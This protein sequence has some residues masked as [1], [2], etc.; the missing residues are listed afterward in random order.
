MSG[1]INEAEGT[2]PQRDPSAFSRWCGRLVPVL[3]ALLTFLVI[4]PSLDAVGEQPDSADAPGLTLDEIFNIQT[5]VYLWRS[6]VLE[7]PGYFTP[8][9]AER[10]Y[11]QPQ[12]NPDHPPLGRLAI[13][14]AHD[15]I[16]PIPADPALATPYSVRAARHASALLFAL[17]VWLVSSYATRW[18][19]L[20]AGLVAAL[21]LALMPR[22]FGH[23]HLAALETA[24]GLTFTWT[25][26]YVADRWCQSDLANSPRDSLPRWRVVVIAGVL[27]GFALLTKI[28]AILL[29]IPIGLWALWQWHWRAIPRLLVF[30][31]VGVAVFFLGWP[32]LW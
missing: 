27:L 21:S 19:G 7:G 1:S 31:L 17:T 32:W 2:R 11:R 25:V 8:D 12:A 29:P 16:A 22:V 28:Q 3:I 4:R 9:G 14:A 5:G 23:A 10:I 18:A 24:I 26:L 20:G 15:L 13:G 30:G 6:L